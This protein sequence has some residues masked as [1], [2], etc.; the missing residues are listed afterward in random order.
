[1]VEFGLLGPLA[2]DAGG[3]R[4]TVSAGK[5]RVLLAALLLRANQ[6]VTS[7]D[8]AD[9]V[10]DGRPP[11]TARVT[12]QN[13]VKRLR[14]ALGPAG[15][16]RIVTR[17]A[18]YLI[19]VGPG[20]L[21]VA[22]F[23]QLQASGRAAAR[24]GA[25]ERSS[26]QLGAAL[27]L[28]RGQPLADVPSQVLAA[29][30]VPRLA[31]LRLETVEDRI[32][33]DLH[34]GRHREVIAELQALTAAEPLRERLYELLMVALYRAGQQAAALAVYR[35]AR[36]TLIENVGIEP[37]PG[38]RELNQRILRS[39]RAL[40]FTPPVPSPA[41]APDDMA[42]VRPDLL[43]A[44]VPGFTGRLRELEVLS[45]LAGGGV[46]VVAIGGTAGVGKTALAVYWARRVAADF[47]DG[48]LYV[49]LRGFGPAEPVPAGEALRG[50]L[51]ALQVPAG[52]IPAGV[53]GR[54]A[55]LRSVLAGRRVLM[56]VDNARDAD[57]VRPLLPGTP[58]SLVLVTSRAELASLVV[59]DG[60]AQISLDVLS[61][62]EAR[63]LLA[64]RLGKARIAAEAAA[65]DA[66][67][68]LCA[69]LP[70]ALAI[71]AARAVAHPDFSLAALAAELADARGRLDA[72][73]T[74]EQATDVRAVLSWS[75]QNLAGPPARLFRLLGLHPGPDITAPAA[76]SLA[77]APLPATRRL[78]REL[79]HCHL[80]AEP[81]PGRYA[82]HDLLRAYATERATATDPATTRHAATTRTLDHYLHTAHT[83]ATLINPAGSRDPLPPVAPGVIPEQL[84]DHQQALAWFQ[85]EQEVLLGLVAAAADARLDTYA[86]QLPRAMTTFLDGRARWQELVAI[87]RTALAAAKR[88]G[89]R[90]AQAIACRN[91]ATACASLGDYDQAHARIAECLELCRQLG[92][93]ASEARAHLILGFVCERQQRPSDALGHSEQALAAF[94][95]VGDRG[96]Q[97]STLNAV[98][99]C[100][101]L[102]GDYRRA[103]A[104]CQQALAMCQEDSNRY[105]E[106]YIWDSL[107]YA[108][109]HLGM[110]ADAIASFGRAVELQA[111]LGNRVTEATSLTRLGDTHQAAGNPDAARAAWQRAL[112]ILDDLEHADAGRLRDK[113]RGPG[114]GSGATVDARRPA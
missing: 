45:G 4:L 113:L 32:D 91:L 36:Q 111:E 50:L 21:D 68:G 35:Q 71:T 62:A 94:T 86:C 23:G 95:E 103:R 93:R 11:G 44:A 43:P 26:S 48:Q 15:Y 17:P 81:V 67:I 83:A 5:Q 7:A 27:A 63:Q 41:P 38:L 46:G 30:E 82:F 66:L 14:Q 25:W 31:E 49:N 69:A 99:W 28:W 54:A 52:Q 77:G 33:A 112:A 58:G 51:D 2:V 85:A 6:V 106:A 84:D 13:Y 105:S 92:D 107:G 73:S 42:A 64:G 114:A 8:L 102:L 1:M 101:A 108:E 39:D 90:G 12:L 37:G 59:A 10:W 40:A 65:A 75:Y 16:E 110:Y 100:S 74:G 80:L 55:L 34:L 60:A 57:Q 109:Q 104:C 29:A 97:I 24:V 78:L 22:R 18:G 20:E 87:Q 56:V 96:G 61:L 3:S 76:A 19:E 9:A 53:A 98:G 70:L 88:L 72:L 79:T 47:P 89:D